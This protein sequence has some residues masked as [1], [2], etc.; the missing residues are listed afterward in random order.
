MAHGGIVR[1]WGEVGMGDED[2]QE[3][4]EEEVEE[5]IHCRW[6]PDWS[7][8]ISCVNSCRILRDKANR[9]QRTYELRNE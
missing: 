6:R 2:M 1:E 8:Y 3:G 4:E 7:M 5:G 9:L